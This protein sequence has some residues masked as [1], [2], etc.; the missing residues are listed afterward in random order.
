[1]HGGNS[2]FSEK[3]RNVLR[4]LL[5]AVL[6]TGGVFLVYAHSLNG[7][8]ALDD[9]L[10]MQPIGGDHIASHTGSRY[11]SY[12]SFAI[13]QRI[14]PYDTFNFRLFNLLIHIV[15]SLLVYI[16]AF[17]TIS[18]YRRDQGTGMSCFPAAL[19]S[20]AIFALHPINVNAVA[21]IIQRMALLAAFFVLLSLISYIVASRSEG[22]PKRVIFYSGSAVCLFLGILSKENAVTGIFLILLYDYV[23]IA[24]YNFRDFKI[25]AAIA[26]IL[27]AG[28]LFAASFYIRIYD[29]FSRILKDF[30][31]FNRPLEWKGWMAVDVSWSPLEH[32]LTGFRVLSRY[33]SLLILPLP[34]RLVFDWWGYP[35]SKGLFTPV[36]TLFS[37]IFIAALLVFCLLRIRRYPFLSFGFLWYFTAV[38]LETFIAIGSDLYYE[39]RNYLPLAGLSFGV[40]AQI[41]SSSG[42]WIP[43]RMAFWIVAALIPAGL[44]LMTFERN[45]IW[46]DP[47]TFWKD[48]VDKTQESPRAKLALA[49]VYFGLSDYDNAGRY[50]LDSISTAD[51]RKSP[52]YLVESLYRYGLMNILL[53]KYE[54]AEKT[55]RALEKT[56]PG[57]Y[58]L[59][60]L[61]GFYGYSTR[62]YADAMK[63]YEEVMEKYY[64]I[65]V[66]D[67]APLFTLAGDA[68]R[69]MGMIEDA[70][71]YYEKAN[72][73]DNMF[74]GAHHGIAKAYMLKGDFG[75]AYDRLMLALRLDPNNVGVLADLA[76]LMLLRG[77]S[78]G[79]ALPFIKK[80]VSFNPPV[81]MPYLIMATVLTASGEDGEADIY[82]AKAGRFRAPDYLII[83]N[84]AWGYSLRG[85]A[86]GE[87]RH[88][89]ELL[90]LHDAPQHIRK[91]AQNRLGRFRD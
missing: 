55:I 64:E 79:R 68:C 1:M 52:Y 23:F 5:A 11:I 2:F 13:N 41:V 60:M 31:L 35:V 14:N 45:H 33:L 69:A 91:T 46:K 32:V 40:A 89:K 53:E 82:Y 25:R 83:F 54:D 20:A 24:R 3:R 34:D 70:M 58:Q 39:H 67:R 28:V 7:I 38:S 57:S 22:L 76:Y 43:N 72:R 51:H 74:P 42:K 49:N 81:H 80:A 66:R 19:F 44:G 59:K 9:S 12:L 10:V 90:K 84:R 71:K 29:M 4:H 86:E 87:K 26:G 88:L 16:T 18:I 8:W 75:Q 17:A 47:V 21:Y 15:N 62:Q 85:D 61:K 65:N 78:A 27:G 36:T 77:D 63:N 37:M 48:A 30:L 56:S 50:Y 73:L 6:L